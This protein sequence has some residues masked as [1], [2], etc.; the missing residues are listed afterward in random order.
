MQARSL[1]GRVRAPRQHSQPI[2]GSNAVPQELVG[3][4]KDRENTVQRQ[5]I[6]DVEWGDTWDGGV[7]RFCCRLWAE[8]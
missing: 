1:L 5:G 3:G 7:L 6:E 8:A 4:R 2:L